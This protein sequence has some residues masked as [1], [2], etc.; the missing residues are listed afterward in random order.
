MSLEDELGKVTNMFDLMSTSVNGLQN[1]NQSG[2]DN[3]A[4]VQ[5]P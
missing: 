4:N 2:L 3:T 1:L 5:I